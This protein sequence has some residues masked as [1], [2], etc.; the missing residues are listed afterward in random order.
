M[1]FLIIQALTHFSEQMT[2][3]SQLRKE[4][5][6]LHVEQIRFQQLRTRL[7]KVRAEM[8]LCQMFLT[9]ICVCVYTR[10]HKYI[11]DIYVQERHELCKKIS[12]AVNCSIAAYDDR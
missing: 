6:T 1:Y 2:K 8:C 12:G 10:T 4:L 5:Q 3:N 7:E 11:Y 9:C